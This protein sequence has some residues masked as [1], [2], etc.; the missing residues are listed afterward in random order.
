MKTLRI[1]QNFIIGVSLLI[2]SF[3]PLW[4][5]FGDE[6][7]FLTSV[8]YR[9]SFGAVFLVMLIRPLADIFRKQLWLR[10]LVILRKSFGIFSASIIIG[11]MFGKIIP[12]H[13]NYLLS[14]F[15][16]EYWSFKN[17][18]FFA[19]LSDITGLILL[20][21]SNNFSMILLKRNW[22]RIQRLAYVYFYSAGIYET[23]NLES[24]LSLWAMVI[25]TIV[26]ITAFILNLRKRKV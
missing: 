19:H 22:K 25:I 18:I 23:Y 13:S 8:L 5:A 4:T 1:F 2:I 7:I 3:L 10:K 16:L 9:I 11:F 12:L 6:N 24:K 21:T 15:T 17:Y 14:I 26:T 20:V